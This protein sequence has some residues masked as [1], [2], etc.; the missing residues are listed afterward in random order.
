MIA[1]VW[2]PD[3]GHP[4]LSHSIW[5]GSAPGLLSKS[6]VVYWRDSVGKIGGW[7]AGIVQP[8]PGLCEPV[9]SEGGG[10]GNAGCLWQELGG[11]G[12]S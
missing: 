8:G 3:E 5:E 4:F 12:G 2:Q 6:W 9:L 10:L 7:D 11:D 1:Q